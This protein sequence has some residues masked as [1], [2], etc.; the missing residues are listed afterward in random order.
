MQRLAR[1]TSASNKEDSPTLR[2]S[3][4]KDVLSTIFETTDVRMGKKT[5]DKFN[6]FNFGD[7]LA[8]QPIK[9]VAKIFRSMVYKI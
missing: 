4:A 5:F 1:S 8:N 9:D 6:K 2:A 3:E 7:S